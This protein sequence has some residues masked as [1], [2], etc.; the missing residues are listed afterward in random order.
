MNNGIVFWNGEFL[1]L[2]EAN[3]SPFDRGFLFGD[4]VYELI[5]FHHK[6]P[7]SL[8]SHLSRL[9]TSLEL[10][11]INNPYDKESWKK[12]ITELVGFSEHEDIYTY[13]QVTRGVAP[14]DHAYPKNIKPSVFMYTDKLSHITDEQASK[15]FQA[16]TLEDFRW[17][18]CNIKSTSLIGNVLLRQEAIE[19][20]YD[21]AILIRGDIATEGAASNI[22]IVVNKT[23]ITPKNSNLLLP[24]ITRDI[25]IEIAEKNSFPCEQK[26]I[27]KNEL[28]AAEEIFLT[29]SGKGVMPVTRINGKDI[30]NGLAGNQTLSILDLYKDHCKEL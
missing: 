29:S 26:D 18:K 23:I 14:R 25:V 6:T 19:G 8:D 21:E 5:P 13:L 12:Y 11:N 16:V 2:E 1:P 27:T 20:G 3:V 9:Q 24:G 15:G 22:F 28:L 7:L 4:G 30:G 17:L 10:V